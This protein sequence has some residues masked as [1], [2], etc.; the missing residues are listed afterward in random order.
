MPLPLCVQIAW[1][2]PILI[3]TA[4]ALQPASVGFCGLLYTCASITLGA[5][6]AAPLLWGALLRAG[7]GAE[8]RE[9]LGGVSLF[10][11]F[12]TAVLMVTPWAAAISVGSN[13]AWQCRTGCAEPA[14]RNCVGRGSGQGANAEGEAPAHALVTS[15]GPISSPDHHP[16]S[17]ARSSSG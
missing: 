10:V 11:C 3:L 2:V 15:C 14:V 16:I 4:T 5:L 17:S 6:G 12:L 7:P 8:R 1:C 9:D 13:G